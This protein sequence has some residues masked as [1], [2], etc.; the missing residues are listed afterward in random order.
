MMIRL[1]GD[2]AAPSIAR[3]FV[4]DQLTLAPEALGAQLKDDVVLVTSE[5]VTN[6][7]QAGAQDITVQIRVEENRIELEVSD[8]GAG[9]P[10]PHAARPHDVR[11]R[12]LAITEALTHD[13][14]ISEHLPVKTVSAT[15]T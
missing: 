2:L 9:W 8:D 15:W 5:L 6:S 10:T 14:S 7:V 4:H 3:E 1:A 12:G 13:W 11:G